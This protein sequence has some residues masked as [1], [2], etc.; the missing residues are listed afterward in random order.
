MNWK[1]RGCRVRVVLLSVRVSGSRVQ[2]FNAFFLGGGLGFG[3]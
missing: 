1:L 2:G 3:F